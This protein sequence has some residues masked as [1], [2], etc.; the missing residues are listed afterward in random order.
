MFK[1]HTDGVN[2]IK[3]IPNEEEKLISY[4]DD[5]TIRIWDLQTGNK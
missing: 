4:S 1:G 3:L 5:E 2:G